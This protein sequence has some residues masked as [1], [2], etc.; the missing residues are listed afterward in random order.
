[1]LVTD[2]A[3][4]I[5]TKVELRHILRADDPLTDRGFRIIGRGTAGVRLFAVPEEEHVVSVAKIDEQEEPENEAEQA[6]AA[7]IAGTSKGANDEVRLDDGTGPETLPDSQEGEGEED[8]P[9]A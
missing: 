4:L 5:R 3:K 6:V 8:E 9:Q 1:M 2:Q 7:E